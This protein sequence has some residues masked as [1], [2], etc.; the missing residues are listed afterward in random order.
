M[1][2]ILLLT[3][4]F[5]IYSPFSFANDYAGLLSKSIIGADSSQHNA[6]TDALVAKLNDLKERGMLSNFVRSFDSI[7]LNDKDIIFELFEFGNDENPRIISLIVSDNM[8]Y[9]IHIYLSYSGKEVLQKF[10]SKTLSGSEKLKLISL[11]KKSN[12]EESEMSGYS[13]K[14]SLLFFKLFEKNFTAKTYVIIPSN[15]F[16]SVSG[17]PLMEARNYALSILGLNEVGQDLSN[18]VDRSLME[19][20][21]L[22]SMKRFKTLDVAVNLFLKG[23]QTPC[24]YQSIWQYYSSSDNRLDQYLAVWI[25]LINEKISYNRDVV[26]SFLFCNQYNSMIDVIKTK[27]DLL[28]IY[29]MYNYYIEN[30]NDAAADKCKNTL[31]EKGVMP[32]L[33]K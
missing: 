13:N 31:L 10:I 5:F 26:F 6:R 30:K 32:S 24:L 11:I 15:G 19:K 25:F 12:L 21:R 33:F 23:K 17:N 28:S 27:N 16:V 29:I 8:V 2:R 4:F 7:N 22:N 14:D 9:Y 18:I 1:K 3:I 20:L